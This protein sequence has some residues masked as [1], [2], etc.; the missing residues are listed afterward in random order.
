MASRLVTC[1]CVVGGSQMGPEPRPPHPALSPAGVMQNFSSR[2]EVQH[3]ALKRL[4]RMPEDQLG[5]APGPSSTPPL[6]ASWGALPAPALLA[7]LL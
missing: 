1:V 5:R 7:G 3:R 2:P 6:R 4:L